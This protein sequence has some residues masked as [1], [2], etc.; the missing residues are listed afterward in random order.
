MKKNKNITVTFLLS[1][2]I[3]CSCASKKAT[4][5][6]VGDVEIKI[7][8]SDFQNDKDYFRASQ[9]GTST[10][11]SQSIKTA[12][13]NAKRSL[14]G[15]IK[16]QMKDVTKIYSQDRNI[17]DTREFS[18]KVETY[19]LALINETLRELN[20]VC[21]KTTQKPNGEYN[22]FIAYECSKDVIYNGIKKT[23]SNDQK[24][25]QDYDE[26]KFKEV[27]DKEMDKLE[28]EQP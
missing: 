5:K 19:T 22:T 3:I 28:K 23:L 8:C 10:D 6:A 13:A 15:A 18:D 20:T 16:T 11:L 17:S 4:V 26:I 24:L 25:R 2:L 9:M 7:P 27:F 1:I 12:E 21:K 14:A